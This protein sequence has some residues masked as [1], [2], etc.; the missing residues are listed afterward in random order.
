VQCV[1]KVA[2]S[3]FKP[4]K[5]EVRSLFRFLNTKGETT[6]EIHRQLIRVYGEDAG[7]RQN[8]AKLC[9]ELTAGRT[10][11]HDD[12]RS[13]RPSVVTARLIQKTE[14]ISL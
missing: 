13:G 9:R 12:K 10:N 11:V 4:A 1:F 3:I 14:K 8:V 7:N 5:R 2:V 6:A